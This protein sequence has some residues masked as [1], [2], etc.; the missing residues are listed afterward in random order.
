MKYRVL[1]LDIDG[2]LTNS[3]KKITPK[4][5]QALE[6]I[7]REGVVVALASGRPAP[8]IEPVAEE[9]GLHRYGGYIL[10]FNGARIVQASTGRVIYEKTLPQKLLP[11]LVQFAQ[12]HQAV[13]LSYQDRQIITSCPEDPYVQIE[14][15]INHMPIKRLDTLSEGLSLPVNKCLLVGDG[16]HM[17]KLEPLAVKEMGESLSF[18]RSEPY[19]L[20]CMPLGIDKA[21][22]LKRLLEHLGYTREEMVTCGDGFNDLSM[23]RYGGLGVAMANAQ[24]VI[25]QAA[26]YITCSNDQDGVAAVANRFF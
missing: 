20:E 22:S 4:T 10:A 19:F 5:K 23:I 18:Y 8:G 7:Q 13:L 2:T 1:V 25:R 26:D 17:E 14:A 15:R 21:N 16:D 24:P 3:Q 6:R 12:D 11:Q 9:I